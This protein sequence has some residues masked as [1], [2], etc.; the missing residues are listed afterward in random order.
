MFR[1]I[2]PL[3]VGADAVATGAFIIVFDAVFID[4][5]NVVIV[6]LMIVAVIAVA[7]AAA[8]I[9]VSVVVAVIAVIVIATGSMISVAVTHF[10]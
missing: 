8:I 10:A 9:S 3:H 1:D 7:A 5:A 6:A 2:Q 4:I